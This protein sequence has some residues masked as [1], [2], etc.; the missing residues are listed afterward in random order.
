M[1]SVAARHNV[2]IN[3]L[4]K[5]TTEKTLGTAAYMM[6]LLR[7]PATTAGRRNKNKQRKQTC[8]HLQVGK[9]P[10]VPCCQIESPLLLL[11]MLHNHEGC[12]VPR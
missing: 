1:Y 7:G 8:C 2:Y 9:M 10:E 5:T 4:F 6:Y 12:R 3:I 11:I